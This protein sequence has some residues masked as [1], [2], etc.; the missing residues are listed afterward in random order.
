MSSNVINFIIA[1]LGLVGI[2]SAWYFGGRQK[3][4]TDSVK[5]MSEMYTSFLNQYKDRMN[6]VMNELQCV[7]DDCKRIQSQFNDMSL[8][9]AKEVEVS[10]NWEKMHNELSKKYDALKAEYEAL[11]KD[12]DKLKKEVHNG[13]T[14]KPKR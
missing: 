6:E 13:V 7:K 4:N 2:P 8:A 9:Y 12:H 3:N 14:N 1:S 11:K 10:Q 5:A